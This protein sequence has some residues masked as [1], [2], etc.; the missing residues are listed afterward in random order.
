M[1]RLFT[2]SN[3]VTAVVIAVVIGMVAYANWRDGKRV[4]VDTSARSIGLPGAP[5][6][7]RED[8]E[9]RVKEMESRLAQRPDDVRAA[10]L[11]AEALVREMR[12]TG[13]AGLAMRAEQILKKALK[14]DPANYETNRMLATLYLSQHRFR[15]AIE[16]AEKN[17]NARPADSVNYGAMGDGHLELGEYAQAFDAFDRMMQLKPSAAAYARVAYAREIQG[18][19]T[20][21]LDAMKMAAEAT[22]ADDPEA[23]AWTRSQ[24]GE[25]YWQMGRLQ[26]AKSAFVDASHAFPGHPF[27]VTGYAKVTAAEGDLKSALNLLEGLARTSPTPDLA[28]RIGDLLER[29]GR[30]AEA[31]RQFALAEA[32]WKSDI[33]EPKNLARFLADHG[34]PQD[35]VKVA[36]EAAASRHDIFTEDAL[37]WSYFKS[38]R[39]MDAQAAIARALETGSKDRDIVAHAAAIHGAAPQVASR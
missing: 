8:L 32:A 37:A 25:L 10:T 27:A 17:R 26:E 36:E 34:K 30:H 5:T 31:E 20:G 38:G 19:L 23:L 33:P 1:K 24:V 12:V 21:A 39:V 35:A 18:N 29:L 13:N 16:A 11:L 14:E 28:A 2:P 9:R 6:T 15:E 22:A 4:R 7:S 3:V